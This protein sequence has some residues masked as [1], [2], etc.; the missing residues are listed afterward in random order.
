MN[1]KICLRGRGLIFGIIP[2]LPGENEEN[3]E[4]P[5]SV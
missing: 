5:H 4:E 1:W 3:H 2:A